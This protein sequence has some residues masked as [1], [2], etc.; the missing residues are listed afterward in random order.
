MF[1]LP[2]LRLQPSLA[3]ACSVR[4]CR[5]WCLHWKCWSGPNC[6]QLQQSTKGRGLADYRAA[7]GGLGASGRGLQ[8]LSVYLAPLSLEYLQAK[9]NPRR[10]LETFVACTALRTVGLEASY[11]D[12]MQSLCQLVLSCISAHNIRHC[13]L[14][15]SVV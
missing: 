13:R 14:V 12:I 15:N 3:S 7:H 4:L 5:I 8:A 1:P 6:A 11:S 10:G 9:I 2:V